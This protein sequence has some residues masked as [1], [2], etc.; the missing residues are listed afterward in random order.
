M[1]RRKKKVQQQLSKVRRQ[2]LKDIRTIFDKN[3][4][5]T[6]NYKQIS[7]R[8]GVESSDAFTRILVQ[9]CLDTFL[10]KGDLEE[11]E[12]GKYKWTVPKGHIEGHLAL[13]SSGNG[14]L[15]VEGMTQDVF[16]PSGKMMSAMH[17]D[18]VRASVSIRRKNGRMEAEIVEILERA[19]HQF[20]GTLQVSDT[21]AF[22]VP[23]SDKVQQ[24]FFIPG[25]WLGE[26]KN[27]E[28]VLVEIV[29]WPAD[30]KNATA[31][32]IRV[33]GKS[34]ENETEMHAILL[35]FGFSVEFPP[36]VEKEADA[37]STE[38]SAEEISSRRDMRQVLTLTIDPEDAKDF[39]DALSIQSLS[40]GLWEV[41]VHIADVSHYVKPGSALEDEARKRATSVYL[42]DRTVPMLPEKLSNGLC[43][44]RPHEDKLTFSV[45]FTI[46]AEGHISNTWIGRTVIHSD[47]RFAYEQAQEIIETGKTEGQKIPSE[48]LLVLHRMA[49]ALRKRRFEHG[50][51]RIES[52]EIKFKLNE[53]GK[54]LSVFVKQSK[55]AN[56]LI[57]EFMLL[58]N[59]AVAEYAGK[60]D[61]PNK[62]V[63]TF[64][65]RVHDLPD[66]DKLKEFKRFIALFGYSIDLTHPK[67]I[68]KGLNSLFDEIKGKPEQQTIE[69]LA[70]RSM[71]KAVYTTNNIGHYGLGFDYY[72]HFTSPIRRYPDVLAH[73]LIADYLIGKPAASAPPLE[74]A[75]K[76]SSAMEKKAAE[77]ERASNR[78]KQVEYMSERRGEVFE[79]MV[80]GLTEWGMYVEIVE[81]KCEG[82]VRLRDIESDFYSFDEKNF[83]VRGQR[84][85]H[86]F[87]MGDRVQVSV[88]QTDLQRRQL[89]FNLE[90]F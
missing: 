17:G 3:P 59:K 34:G 35:E 48:P 46:N 83:C 68:T 73:R 38:I 43:S 71:A 76:H 23:D 6:L 82:M 69:S 11:V 9:E 25:K 63:K 56:H 64:V 57:E 84:K 86:L 37:I 49:L 65:Y 30:G 88:K 52:T 12:P 62:Q 58:A 77:A 50:A 55:E 32:V 81:N 85:G 27:G 74:D 28:K 45:V 66:Q 44:L 78:Y 1:A 13:V 41:G 31:K 5:Q 8:C 61:N 21:Y 4:A 20:V 26:A 39:D 2:L 22:L 10:Q 14:F 54:P 72:S 75:C 79:G 24:D 70:I 80:S 90:N 18:K 19:N 89:D 7:S 60:K 40:D 33:L 87:R 42:V 29:E 16:I 15:A 47:Q 51:L 67:N 36:A 53:K